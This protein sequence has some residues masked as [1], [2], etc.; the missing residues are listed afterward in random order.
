MT[1]HP[2]E[3]IFH[4]R[5]IAVV[6]ASPRGP[7]T[8][9]GAFLPALIEQGYDRE[10]G[11]YPV[12]P[13]V[14]EVSGLRC[15]P[16]LLDCPDP[17][18]HVISQVPAAAVPQILEHC[19]EKGAHSLHL[20]TAGFS[21]TRDASMTEIEQN[22]VERARVAGIRL[23]GPNCMGLYV[24]EERLTFMGGFPEEPGNVLLLSQ[25][26]SNARAIIVG[27]A[28]RG[29]RFSKAISFGN[30]ADLDA[31][32]FF[33]YAASDPQTDLVIAYIESVSA[34]RRLFEAVKRCAAGKP[35][36]ILKGGV[37]A[38]GARAANSHTGALSG[39]VDIF[40]A[41]CRQT[42]AIRAETMDGLQDLVIAAST[43]VRRVAG[44]GV[45]LA[46]GGG[47]GFAVLSADAVHAAG[48][49]VPE[50]PLEVQQELHEFVR[51]AGTSVRNPIDANMGGDGGL[52][53]YRIVAAAAPV[54]IVFAGNLLAAGRTGPAPLSDGGEAIREEDSALRSVEAVGRLQEESGVP[55]VG[56]MNRDSG[57][58][59]GAGDSATELAFERGLAVFPTV[60]RAAQAISTLLQWRERREDLPELF[61]PG[62]E[63][64]GS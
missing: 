34:G 1:E 49:E 40:E 63:L 53:M 22:L 14:E 5:S 45:A 2:L 27:L 8:G 55:F 18:D 4:P 10:H 62:A 39:S 33:D 17:V 58:G 21:E 46:A 15:Y 25:S 31:P 64:R 3:S 36:I 56:I 47:G 32:D 28:Q 50:M 29:I 6:G 51:V 42:G 37:N 35:T 59:A 61:A 20:F 57:A 23:L 38:S 19:I 60:Q 41:L 54:D 52:R 16:T 30:G 13:G 43:D 9:V 26:G 12:N 7:Q 48:L 24:P 44:P 11:L